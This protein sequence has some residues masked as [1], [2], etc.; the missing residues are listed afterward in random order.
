[1]ARTIVSVADL[2]QLPQDIQ[3][4]NFEHNDVRDSQLLFNEEIEILDI[5]GDWCHV[6]ALEQLRHSPDRGW[7]PYEGWVHQ[8][9]IDTGLTSSKQQIPRCGQNSNLFPF[10]VTS[11][12]E[13]YSYG[14][15]LE[16]QTPETSP[17]PKNFDRQK[18]VKE[19]KQF[20][21]MPYLWGGRS[22]LLPGKIASVDCS[23]LVQLLY[24][25]QGISLPR[26][27]HDQFLW[28]NPVSHSLPGDALYLKKGDRISHVILKL[29]DLFFIE[30]PETGK[31]V[32]LLQMGKDIWQ[33]DGL[34]HFYDRTHAY[35][36]FYISFESTLWDRLFFP[37]IDR[38]AS[39]LN[40]E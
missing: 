35:Q 21:G 39:E 33:V 38:R 5:Q 7:H 22:T 17:I 37:T 4:K 1:M 32:R 10:V 15:Y 19:A 20:L 28:G 31:Q 12:S 29:D 18:L 8:S 36:G 2:R 3:S 9:E 40:R 14:T 27:A 6:A 24:R 23:G 30:S 13:N 34:W 26:D 11:R 16:F 25:A